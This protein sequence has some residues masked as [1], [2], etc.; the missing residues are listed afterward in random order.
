MRDAIVK[1]IQSCDKYLD[2]MNYADGTL[3]ISMI[4]GALRILNY[5]NDKYQDAM[6]K[7]IENPIQRRN[8]KDLIH[9]ILYYVENFKLAEKEN[10]KPLMQKTFKIFLY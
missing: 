6:I 9:N 5:T 3:N 8:Q 4:A 1:V 7:A 2:K 10:F